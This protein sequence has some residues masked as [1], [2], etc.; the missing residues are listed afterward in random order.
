[1]GLNSGTRPRAR[2]RASTTVASTKN[3]AATV[4]EFWSP[5]ET[6]E[7]RSHAATEPQRTPDQPTTTPDHRAKPELANVASGNSPRGHRGNRTRILWDT[8]RTRTFDVPQLS[9]NRF[10]MPRNRMVRHGSRTATLAGLLRAAWNLRESSGT[11]ESRMLWA[12]RHWSCPQRGESS[13]SPSASIRSVSPTPPNATVRAAPAR[14][15]RVDRRHDR[16]QPSEP[17]R[18]CCALR[19]AAWQCPPASTHRAR[20]SPWSVTPPRP[21]VKQAGCANPWHTTC[22]KPGEV[23]GHW[24]CG[25]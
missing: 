3:T 8:I 6:A 16:R 24:R 23:Q 5:P 21:V 10:G 14:R 9:H 15:R 13:G 22:V 25:G 2:T 20:W 17:S 11:P 1:M 12:L 18:E 4:L 19:R 7:A